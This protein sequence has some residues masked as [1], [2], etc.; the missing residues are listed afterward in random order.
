MIT[1][2][3]KPIDEV[4]SMIEAYNKIIVAGCYGCVTVCRVG[5]DK[6]VQVLSSTLRLARE[7]AGRPVE[8]K[9]VCLERQ[10]D[11][12]ILSPCAPTSR[13]IRR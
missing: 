7:A 2:T 13:I 10:C 3:P 6:E 5:G 1:G 8:I 4:L 12:N 11:P 9:E